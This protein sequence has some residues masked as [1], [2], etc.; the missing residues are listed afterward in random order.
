MT[1]PAPQQQQKRTNVRAIPPW[2]PG[3]VNR[4]YRLSPRAGGRVFLE[5]FLRPPRITPPQREIDWLRGS[6]PQA[7]QVGGRRLRGFSRG[8]GPVV[9][10]V[11]GWAGRGSQMGAFIEPL[12]ANGF[13]VVGI[14]LPAHGNS[15]G[16]RS[17]IPECGWAVEHLLHLH[18]PVYGVIAHSMGG[19]V[20]TNALSQ[21]GSVRRLV[22]LGVGN[23]VGVLTRRAATQMNFA[24]GLYE[25]F[26]R[27]AE[28]RFKVRFVDYVIS[29][30]APNRPESM[31]ALHADDDREVPLSDARAWTD[32][33][34]GAQLE[35]HAGLGHTRIL[36]HPDIVARAT[37]FMREGRSASAA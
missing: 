29:S 31:L 11:H 27:L 5:A 17:S 24:P 33:W 30:H 32:L 13:R 9:L 23:D 15:D 25:E 20:T 35:V 14:D 34:R 21:V 36:R 19:V 10:L 26:Q 2:V 37:D 3:A 12:V 22:Y 18:E 4:L 16:R 6:E 7:W 1:Q 8:D 28:T